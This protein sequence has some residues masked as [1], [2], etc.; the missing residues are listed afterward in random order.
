MRIV[1][2]IHRVL[3]DASVVAN[4]IDTI[5]LT[6]GS[7]MVPILRDKILSLFP[8]AHAAETDLL[9]SVGIGLSLDARRKF[10]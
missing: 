6:G 2:T 7:S 8:K 1:A 9:G 4:D 10:S 5:V 3:K